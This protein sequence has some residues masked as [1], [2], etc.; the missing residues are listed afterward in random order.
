MGFTKLSSFAKSGQ[1]CSEQRAGKTCAPSS[2]HRARQLVRLQ[3][4]ATTASRFAHLLPTLD[5]R[6]HV[7][8]AA[9]ELAKD[10]LTRHLALEMLDGSL[11]ALVSDLDFKGLALNGF[12]GIRQGTGD[13]ADRPGDCKLL[14]GYSASSCRPT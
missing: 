12:A 7:V 9:L 11:D 4:L 3:T 5:R 10:A 2:R 14:S 6:L 8:T 13:M 1:D